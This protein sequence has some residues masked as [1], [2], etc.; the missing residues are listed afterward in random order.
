MAGR[1][2]TL[3]FKRDEDG[4]LDLNGDYDYESVLHMVNVKYAKETRLGLGSAVYRDGDGNL[5]GEVL[6]PFDYSARVIFSI[7][8]FAKKT[9]TQIA[10]VKALSDPTAKAQGWYGSDREV[11]AFYSDDPL[12]VLDGVAGAMQDKFFNHGITS[13]LDFYKCDEHQ[14]EVMSDP[15]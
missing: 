14:L 4:K 15:E 10:K 2:Y 13:L 12:T 5:V 11:A 1:N 3:K 9:A 7:K 6:E 8:D